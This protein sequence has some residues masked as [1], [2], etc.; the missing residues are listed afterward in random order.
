MKK[1]SSV[2]LVDDDA[3]TN[4]LN[5]SLLRD[6]QVT[7]QFVVARNGVEALTLLE[8]QCVAPTTSCPALILLD[9][10]MP[11]LNGIEFLEA[12]HH[13]P[14][15]HQQA[16]IIVVLTTSMNSA[17]LARLNELPIAGLASKPLTAEKINTI[18]PLHFQRQLPDAADGE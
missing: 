9:I 8:S 14:R 16:I 6:L 17:D 4:F 1:L 2:L 7:D 12:F 10:N 15:A 13:L 5:E 3:T 18:L 11:V